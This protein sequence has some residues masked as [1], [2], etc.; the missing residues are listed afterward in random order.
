MYC[1]WEVKLEFLF[2]VWWFFGE[3][4]E[5]KLEVYGEVNGVG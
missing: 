3:I 4:R 2:G 5:L 1:V